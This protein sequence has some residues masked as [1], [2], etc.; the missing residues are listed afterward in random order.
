MST[1]LQAPNPQLNVTCILPS[2]KFLDSRAANDALTVQRSMTGATFSYVKSSAAS[3]R[4]LPFVLSRMKTLELKEFIRVYYRA[5]WKV[6]LHD[7]TVWLCRLLSNPFIATAEGRAVGWP[8]N[9]AVAITLELSVEP[10]A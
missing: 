1:V 2:A 8:G 3:T 6:T 9:E 10:Y 7:G 5:Q 4:S